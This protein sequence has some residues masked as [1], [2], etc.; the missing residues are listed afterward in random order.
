MM[1]KLNEVL[2]A[3]EREELAIREREIQA[4]AEHQG[5][6]FDIKEALRRLA[7]DYRFSYREHTDRDMVRVI[8]RELVSV[9]IGQ[10]TL[11]V[12]MNG[13]MV[14]FEGHVPPPAVISGLVEIMMTQ[15]TEKS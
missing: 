9:R 11:V 5:K 2:T 3:H 10:G 12:I 7:Q 8:I 14:S 13:T 6:L 4:R 1:S 15:R